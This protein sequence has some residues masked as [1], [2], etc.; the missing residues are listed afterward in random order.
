MVMVL[1]REGVCPSMSCICRALD[2]VSHL[3]HGHYKLHNLS[4]YLPSPGNAS[5]VKGARCFEQQDDHFEIEGDSSY[6]RTDVQ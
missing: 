6:A 1:D 2:G 5:L 4:S 3:G